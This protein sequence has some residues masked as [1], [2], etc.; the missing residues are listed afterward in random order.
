ML[1]IGIDPA[2]RRNGFWIAIL[3]TVKRTV[4]FKGFKNYN[5]FYKYVLKLPENEQYFFAI[6]N[7]NLDNVSYLTSDNVGK[8]A[9]MSRDA[10]KNQ[11]VSQ[12]CVDAVKDTFGDDC[13]VEYS[14]KS[15]SKGWKEQYSE[16]FFPSIL[17]SD[18]YTLITPCT[19]QDQRDA[20]HL[21][22]MAIREKRIQVKA[23]A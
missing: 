2:A 9:K 19:N 13:Y 23:V 10:G 1:V 11:Q 16:G 20:Y 22:M 8:A 3:D 5:E 15:K 7:S 12:Q 14:G 6:E 4:E 21:A 17:R 18:K